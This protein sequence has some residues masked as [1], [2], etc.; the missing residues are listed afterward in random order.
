[1]TAAMMAAMAKIG[2]FIFS[3]GRRVDFVFVGSVRV[4]M[5]AAET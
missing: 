2:A 5:T 1:M 3:V 4:E